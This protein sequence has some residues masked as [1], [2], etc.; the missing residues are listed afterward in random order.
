MKLVHQ[1]DELQNHDSPVSLAA[2]FFDGMHLGHR[3]VIETAIKSAHSTDGEAWVLTFD[4]H[5]LK[6]LNPGSAPLLL[7][8]AQHKLKL[9]KECNVDG[10]IV[11]PFT[12]QLAAMSP[13]D[14][15][16]WLFHCVPSLAEVVTGKNWR[17]GKGGAGCP[18]LLADL[19]Y[20]ANVKVTPVSPVLINN[21]PISSTRIRLS[22]MKGKLDD[23][24]KMLGRSF[25]V[26]GTVV[27]G[28]AIG[29]EIGYP[30][31]N[32]D[33]HNEALP[34]LGVYAVKA[35]VDNKM[36]NGILNFGTRPTFNNN[37]KAPS[38]LELHIFDFA[39]SI[40]DKDIEAFFIEHL[41]DEWYFSSVEELKSQI[42]LDISKAKEILAGLPVKT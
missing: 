19:G 16:D 9:I 8:S 12:K 42:A 34:P 4:T 24:A 38:T 30:S 7:T 39:E 21:E 14:F 13:S 23:A 31:A 26:L 11:L 41:R 10:C 15:A 18:D 33:P 35:L 17:F 25:S 3:K 20:K 29:R 36:Y 40:Y 1:L 5:P 22:V 28:H 2:G 6:I 27:K 37:K 32:L